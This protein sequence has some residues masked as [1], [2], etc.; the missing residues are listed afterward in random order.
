MFDF[1]I[2]YNTVVPTLNVKLRAIMQL[3]LSPE[4][5]AYAPS[6]T[7]PSFL[8]YMWVYITLEPVP[9]VNKLGYYADVF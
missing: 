9:S 6:S 2:I 3:L 7:P 8:A 4:N 5:S 1:N